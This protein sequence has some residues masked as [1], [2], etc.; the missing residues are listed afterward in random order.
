MGGGGNVE[1]WGRGNV[2]GKEEC[3]KVNFILFQIMNQ[4][5]NNTHKTKKN[6]SLVGI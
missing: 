2:E 4:L 3:R 6:I 1:G 5:R